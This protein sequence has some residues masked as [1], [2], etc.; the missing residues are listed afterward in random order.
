MVYNLV[1]AGFGSFPAL[2]SD[3]QWVTAAATAI[4]KEGAEQFLANLL[5]SW[6]CQESKENEQ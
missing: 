6:S 2:V 1:Y 3:E 5:Y 4:K